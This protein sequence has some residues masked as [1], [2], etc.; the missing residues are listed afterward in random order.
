MKVVVVLLAAALVIGGLVGTLIVRDP[1]YVLVAYGDTTF[2]TSLWFG[3]FTLAVLGLLL[4]GVGYVAVRTLRGSS[5]ISQWFVRRRQTVARR[6][7]LSGLLQMAEGEWSSA[8]KTLLS[9]AA[10]AETPLINYLNAA[11]AAHELDDVDERD[12]LLRLAHETTP[13]SKF[14]VALTQAQLHQDK[15]QWEQC[16]AALIQ[17]RKESPKHRL[18]LSMLLRCYHELQDWEALQDLVPELV[19]LKIGDPDELLSI[20]RESWL[21][22]LE[23]VWASSELAAHAGN[24]WNAIP[25][26]LKSEPALVEQ[27]VELLYAGGAK[28][29][30][31]S[32]LRNAISA[33]WREESIDRY[34]RLNVDPASQIAA[35]EKWLKDRPNN[36]V[37][38]LALGRLCMMDQA[39]DKARE[40]FEASL[41]LA[42]TPDVYGELGRL[43]ISLG[44]TERGGEYLLLA[45]NTLPEVALPSAPTRTESVTGEPSAAV[46]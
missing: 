13:G 11:R 29:E 23:R 36:P 28:Q 27:Y 12:R 6:K 9:V 42:R 10:E 44:D 21:A 18:V 24:T 22:R 15:G 16:L 3:F 2:E 31:E 35:A 46:S 4:Y 33:D 19:K 17:L 25:K 20:E 45:Q 38:L 32:I 7:T 37:L 1:G 30:A 14:A 39:W 41:R 40:Y 34:G 8:K 26:R 43:C 5:D